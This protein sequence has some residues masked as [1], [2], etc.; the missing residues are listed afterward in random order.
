MVPAS[1]TCFKQHNWFLG[2]MQ[3]SVIIVRGRKGKRRR[4][5]REG[6]RGEGEGRGRSLS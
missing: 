2:V 3:S 4:R 5:G 1:H 6:G